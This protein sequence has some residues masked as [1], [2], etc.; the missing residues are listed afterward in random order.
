MNMLQTWK[1]LSKLPKGKQLFSKILCWKVPYFKTIHPT[2]LHLDQS[3]C[4][5][6]VPKRRAIENHLST[7]HAIVMCNMAELAGGALLQVCLPATH[8]F[9]PKGMQVEYLKK[10]KT[11]LIAKAIHAD[12]FKIQ[13]TSFEHHV[14]IEIKDHFEDLV[15]TANIKMWVSPKKG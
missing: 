14:L 10:A 7:V 4:Q 9:I 11:D 8:H 2:I 13:Q 5:V 15:F 6:Y 12:K 1:R 3:Q